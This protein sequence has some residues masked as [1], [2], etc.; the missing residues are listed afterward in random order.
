[1]YCLSN[2]DLAT[3]ILFMEMQGVQGQPA[4]IGSKIENEFLKWSVEDLVK[5]SMPENDQDKTARKKAV[6]FLAE[7]ST[8]T[9]LEE[10]NLQHGFAPSISETYLEYCRFLGDMA[11]QVYKYKR[12][13]KVIRRLRSKWNLSFSKY[14]PHDDSTPEERNVLVRRLTVE[15]YSFFLSKLRAIL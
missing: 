15:A 7:L 1:V 6:L 11:P 2:Y 4:D 14:E 13:V 8:V 9:W 12:A 10:Q 3:A 5:I